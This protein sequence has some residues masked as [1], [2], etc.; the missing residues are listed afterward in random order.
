VDSLKRVQSLFI[1]EEVKSIWFLSFEAQGV[2]SIGG[3][4]RAVY[5]LARELTKAGFRVHLIMPSHGRHLD[6]ETA[7]RLKLR[8]TGAVI[9]GTRRGLDGN[10]YPY[11]LGVEEGQMEG[12]RLLLIK[13][14]DYQSGRFLDSWDIYNEPL[15]K[16]SLVARAVPYL[17][18]KAV[19][20]SEIPDLIHVHDWHMVVPGT[21][22]KQE[23]EDRRIVI[24]LVY[25]IHLLGKV[26]IPWHYA[27]ED[28]SG[29]G[30]CK[31]YVWNVVKHRLLSYREIW[32]SLGEGYV[33]KF[34]A[35]ECDLL[36]TVSRNYLTFDLYNFLGNW[37]EN[38]SCVIYNGTDWTLGQAKSDAAEIFSTEDRREVRRKILSHL[39]SLRVIPKDYWSGHILWNSRGP[40]GI[41][42][43][44]T[45]EKLE[46][47]PLILFAGRISY[48]KGPDLLARAFRRVLEKTKANLIMLGIPTGDYSLLQD[49]VN[50]LSESKKARIILGQ[51][52]DDRLYRSFFYAADV[53]AMPSRWEPFGITA[54]E[55]MA[56]GT[57][58]VGYYVGGIAESVKDLRGGM[59][60]TGFLAYPESIEDLSEALLTAVKLAEA[61][62]SGDRRHLL[63]IPYKLNVDDVHLWSR[64][65]QNSV[66]R[67]EMLFRWTSSARQA[68]ECYGKALTMA[69]Y[70]AVS[71]M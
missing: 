27:S 32:D 71:S 18:Q 60:G 21:V 7:S 6:G 29:L 13:G 47:A 10:F 35:F 36:S 66:A 39:S 42:E 22:A 46:D 26:R 3:L 31:H 5:S 33:E 70:R 28:W 53:F 48:Q 45:Y 38:K 61:D 4:G 23:F 14:L 17:V 57:P 40:L 64:V 51:F 68:M 58:V 69:K 67:V 2:A 25:S 41:R 65:R 49:V 20:L 55:S 56:V 11:S 1:P 16:A 37:V 12:I 59:D 8:D 43:D 44:W 50:T 19:D 30:N 52:K 15:E 34:G 62:E 54:I 24:P 63:E 9:R